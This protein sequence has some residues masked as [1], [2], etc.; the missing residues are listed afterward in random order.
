MKY[1]RGFKYQLAE[2]YEQIVPIP[3]DVEIR[4]EF[5]NLEP[6]DTETSKLIIKSGY[7]C[8]G[9]SGI[10]IDSPSS[11]RPA[12]VHDAFYQLMRHKHLPKSLRKT[13]DSLLLADL[14]KEGMDEGRAKV[15]HRMVRIFGSASADPKNKKK[16]YEAP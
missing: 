1:R 11:I 2:R 16:I 8:D 12:F 14:I 4:T 15:W 13:I 5:I 3:I 9:P 7:A 6:I 10:T